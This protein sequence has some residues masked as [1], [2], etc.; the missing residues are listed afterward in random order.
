MF[1]RTVPEQYESM[2]AKVDDFHGRIER[3]GA[4]QAAVLEYRVTFSGQPAALRQKQ[5]LI[6]GGGNTYV[7]TCAARA[8]IFPEYARTFGDIVA[9][10]KV[11]PPDDEGFH[12][13][14]LWP[15]SMSPA[16]VGAVCAVIGGLLCLFWKLVWA[17]KQ[18]A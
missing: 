14:R 12:W 15:G 9:S 13:N 3:V 4:N 6:P 5:V 1:Q 8:D 18:T 7:V 2:G 10:M 16:V 11:P 17:R